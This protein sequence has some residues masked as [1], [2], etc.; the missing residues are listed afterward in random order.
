SRASPEKWALFT[1]LEIGRQNIE[2]LTRPPCQRAQEIED[3]TATRLDPALNRASAPA[4]RRVV[5]HLVKEASHLDYPIQDYRS[6][7][8]AVSGHNGNQGDFPTKGKRRLPRFVDKVYQVGRSK[9]HTEHQL[10]TDCQKYEADQVAN[11]LPPLL[12]Q[13]HMSLG[14]HIVPQGPGHV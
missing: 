2:I 13:V 6:N 8:E 4:W 11:T 1:L 7:K 14:T 9:C 3:P 10:H 12:E 5:F